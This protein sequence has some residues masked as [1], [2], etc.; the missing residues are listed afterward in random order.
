MSLKKINQRLK[1]SKLPYVIFFCFTLLLPLSLFS[2]N[3]DIILY[4]GW[5]QRLSELE[6][7]FSY[8][9]L[10]DWTAVKETYREGIVSLQLEQQIDDDTIILVVTIL[11]IILNQNEIISETQ[12]MLESS[13]YQLRS[14]QVEKLNDTLSQAVIMLDA[15]AG[16]KESIYVRSAGFSKSGR[17]YL[18]TVL[19]REESFPK[20]TAELENILAAI[21]FS[22]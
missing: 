21:D 4:D 16:D 12:K 7:D 22:Q 18:F 5:E 10:N 1:N 15:V 13:L 3:D 2:C 17:T 20:A 19:A 14:I 11:P 6:P 8:A 9:Y